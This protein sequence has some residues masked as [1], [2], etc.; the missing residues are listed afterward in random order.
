LFSWFIGG[1]P[2][3]EVSQEFARGFCDSQFTG[4]SLH[5]DIGILWKVDEQICGDQFDGISHEVVLE[6]H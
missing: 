3:P 4:I 2:R 5:L 1:I 6:C